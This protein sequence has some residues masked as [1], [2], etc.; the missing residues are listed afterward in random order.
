MLTE[1][2]IQILERQRLG[3]VASVDE[4]GVPSLS[5]KGTFIAISPTEITFR[6]IRSPGTRRNLAMQPHTEVNF[7]TL[8][9]RRG[10]RA[11]GQAKIHSAETNRFQD[12]RPRFDRWGNLADRIRH[13]IV[14]SLSLLLK[15]HRCASPATSK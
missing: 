11:R 1:E 12:L 6:D 5:P 2:M 7:V 14:I 8:L 13:I 10:G 4:T 3:F 15:R 9:A